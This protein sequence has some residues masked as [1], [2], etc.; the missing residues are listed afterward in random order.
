M[1]NKTQELRW[2]VLQGSAQ[3]EDGLIRYKPTIMTDGPQSGQAVPCII[4]S[5][6]DFESGSVSFCEASDGIGKV[7]SLSY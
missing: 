7:G 5:D 4:R 1:V 2:I 6:K 3:F